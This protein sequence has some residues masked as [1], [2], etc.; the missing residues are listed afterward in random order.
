MATICDLCHSGIKVSSTDKTAVFY[1]SL[2]S[3]GIYGIND[4]CAD[5]K[6]RLTDVAKDAVLAEISK[7]VLKQLCEDKIKWTKEY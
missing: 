3:F 1:P 2:I 6:K 7:T 4:I 5:C